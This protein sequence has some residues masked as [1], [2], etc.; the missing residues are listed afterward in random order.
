MGETEGAYKELKARNRGLHD[1]YG[2]WPYKFQMISLREPQF[3]EQK[4]GKLECSVNQGTIIPEQKRGKSEIKLGLVFIVSDHVYEFEMIC[5]T[6]T[7]SIK[8]T[9]TGR[10]WNRVEPKWKDISIFLFF[11]VSRS[12]KVRW[13]RRL[14]LYSTIL[15]LLAYF[16]KQLLIE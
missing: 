10:K 7:I 16:R 15:R 6:G 12:R 11:F 14:Q 2:P 3:I 5:L 9:H 13:R 4:L 1:F 8:W